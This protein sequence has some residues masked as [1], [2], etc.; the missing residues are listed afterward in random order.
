MPKKKVVVAGGGTS[1]WLAAAGIAKL[2][3]NTVEVSL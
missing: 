2:L 3:G 1:G